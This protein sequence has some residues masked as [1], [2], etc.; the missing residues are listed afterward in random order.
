[1]MKSA[2][3]DHGLAAQSR[4]DVFA[5]G[6][7]G[8]ESVV[9][10]AAARPP[11]QR[12]DWFHLSMR[13]RPSEQMVDRVAPLVPDAAQRRA[14]QDG[15]PRLRCQV[16]HGRWRHAVRRLRHWSR[17]LRWAE[18]AAGGADADRLRRFRRH[19]VGLS[20]YLRGNAPLLFNYGSAWR[21]GQRISTAIAE[22]TMNHLVNVRMGETPADAVVGRRR[23][24]AAAG[25]LRAAR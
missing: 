23:P 24:T 4:L 14:L 13:L 10:E 5:D 15:A 18:R 22:S 6:A 16:W 3:D 1:M 9:R 8:L 2:L 7:D 21:T 17:P 19:L 11:L 12:L 20:R 25:P